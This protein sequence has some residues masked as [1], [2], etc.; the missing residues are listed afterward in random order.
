[1]LTES[2]DKIFENICSSQYYFFLKKKISLFL[3]GLI[4]VW[5]GLVV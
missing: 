4:V 2:D 3:S 5:F 1:M